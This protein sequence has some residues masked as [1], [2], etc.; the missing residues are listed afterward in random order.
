[1]HHSE[2][3]VLT[4]WSTKRPRLAGFSVQSDQAVASEAPSGSA[5]VTVTLG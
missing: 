1:M 2:K 3:R 4:Y 5:T